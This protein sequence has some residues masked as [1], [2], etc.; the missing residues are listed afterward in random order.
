MNPLLDVIFP[1]FGLLGMGWTAARLDW[2]KVSTVDGLTDFAYRFAVP[3]LLLRT[4]SKATLPE[5][6]PWDLLISYYGSS[7]SILGLGMLLSRGI[8]GRQFGES[9]IHGF[10]S[11]FPNTVMLGIP[12][13]LIAFGEAATLPLFLI[14]S[15]HSTLLFP[16]ITLLMEFARGHDASV[17]KVVGNALR[18]LAANPII[19]GLSGGLLLNVLDWPLPG[20]LDR[21]AELMASTVAP[22]SLFA[23]GATL[24]RFR[25]AGR[26][27]DVVLVVL[28]KSFLQP[29]VVAL[30]ALW[31]FEL[32]NPLWAQVAIVLA[33]QPVGINPYL[34]ATRYQTNVA[35]AS[36]S[37]LIT[38]MLTPFTLSLLLWFFHAGG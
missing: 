1:V 12:V 28:A 36:N 18:G 5:Q 15:L 29:L 9:A 14:I 13:V 21:V 20:P 32:E 25:I 31:V 34:F 35:L 30:F 23:L 8:L 38:T 4:L 37:M 33:A 27:K 17:P 16:V 11:A 24:T 10:T 3:L 26:W 6:V 19:L 2:A 22:C 7:F